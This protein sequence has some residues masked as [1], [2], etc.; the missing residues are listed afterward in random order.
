MYLEAAFWGRSGTLAADTMPY[1]YLAG[2]VEGVNC[3]SRRAFSSLDAERLRTNPGGPL[4]VALAREPERK[5]AD[6]RQGERIS[7][8]S[9]MA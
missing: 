8:T 3:T 7:A 5:R 1:L 4:Y 2:P 6:G 9:G